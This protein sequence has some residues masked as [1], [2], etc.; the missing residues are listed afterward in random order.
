MREKAC[1]E[2]IETG[3]TCGRSAGEVHTV[4]SERRSI[5][6]LYLDAI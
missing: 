6:T 3:S 5:W 2:E 4:D 1:T